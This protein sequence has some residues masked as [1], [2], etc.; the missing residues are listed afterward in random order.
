V[1]MTKLRSRCRRAAS[2]PLT[3][4]ASQA[5]RWPQPH[6]E[7]RTLETV[8]VPPRCALQLVAARLCHPSAREETRRSR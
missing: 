1:A 3:Q 5:R 6:K 2:G 8:N 7:R 4:Q